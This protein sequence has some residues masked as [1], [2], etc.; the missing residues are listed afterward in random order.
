MSEKS[1]E[2]LDDR[3]L[4][5]LHERWK[6]ARRVAPPDKVGDLLDEAAQQWLAEKED[7]DLVAAVRQ[8]DDRAWA[9]LVEKYLPRARHIARSILADPQIAE[10]VA[11]ECF[12]E[13]AIQRER[14][15]PEEGF[16]RLVSW[17]AKRRS[18][19]EAARRKRER[20][21]HGAVSLEAVLEDNEG[22]SLP[23]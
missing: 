13:L 10:Q 22:V 4:V 23:R 21:F 5:E 7:R 1:A 3:W 16:E 2:I 19:T 12:E 8:G 14:L 20:E 9:R 6:A 18:L 15:H 11:V 17:I